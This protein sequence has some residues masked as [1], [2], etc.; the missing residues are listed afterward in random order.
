[1]AGGIVGLLSA[2]VALGGGQLAAGV[3]GGASSPIVAVGGAAIDLSPGAL[4]SFAIRTFGTNDK[5]VLVSGIGMVLA[6]V[7]VALG[8]RSVRRP[9]SGAIG[10]FVFG[11]IGALAA[12]TR[13]ANGPGDAVPSIAGAAIGYGAYVL[14]RRAAGVQPVRWRSRPEPTQ[15]SRR[16]RP[17]A[18][19]RRRFLLTGAAAAAAAAASAVGG[20]YLIR[21]ADA[22]SSRASVRIP[23]PSDVAPPPPAGA[24]LRLPGLSSFITPNDEFYR[25]DTALVVEDPAFPADHLL[26]MGGDRDCDRA[27]E[28]HSERGVQ[29]LLVGRPP[30]EPLRS[31]G[32]ARSPPGRSRSGAV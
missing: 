14:L 11:A 26:L 20:Q 19:D 18:F 6:I 2:G 4:K 30:V 27:A 23:A 29:V 12:V 3:I 22:S 31:P 10:L 9:R 7:A 5:L 28:H 25:V 32:L 15:R 1:M 16:A 21:R 24:D 8:V 13:P 17:P